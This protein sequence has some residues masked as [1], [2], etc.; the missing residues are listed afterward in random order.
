[1]LLFD[2]DKKFQIW[3]GTVEN[4]KEIGKWAKKWK[5]LTTIKKNINGTVTL[6]ISGTE[7]GPFEC[8][9][10]RSRGG[11]LIFGGGELYASI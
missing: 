8:I 4:A 9:Y 6:S 7:V 10:V 5:G 1:M 11:F 3:D 2:I